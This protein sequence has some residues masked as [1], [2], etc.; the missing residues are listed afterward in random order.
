MEENNLQE[1]NKRGLTVKG[2]G[3]F[4][5]IIALIAIVSNIPIERAIFISIKDAN[6]IL[7]IFQII[8]L[9]VVNIFDLLLVLFGLY[10]VFDAK[11]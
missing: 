7:A 8:L 5:M 6:I 10:I 4:V 3:I 11:K 9:L 1:E 2:L